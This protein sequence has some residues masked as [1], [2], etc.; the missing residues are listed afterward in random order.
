MNKNICNLY[1]TEIIHKPMI[2]KAE[3]LLQKN[4]ISWIESTS[5]VQLDDNEQ[6]FIPLGFSLFFFIYL[7]SVSV[8][9]L[10]P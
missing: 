8:A 1:V 5:Y 7:I 9:I 10:K 2:I 6:D 4:V 3:L